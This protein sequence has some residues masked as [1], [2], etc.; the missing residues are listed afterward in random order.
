[1]KT[2]S[3]HSRYNPLAEAERYIASLTLNEKARFFILIEPGLGYMVA[4][5][6]K[7]VPGAKIVALHAGKQGSLDSQCFPLYTPEPP[8]SQWYPE[9]GRP[10]QDFLEG[11]IPDC[12]AEEIRILEWRP[13][14]AVYGGSYLALVEETAEFV[15][16]ADA[17]AKTT[18]SFGRR[19]VRNFFKNLEIIRKVLCPA[20]L[21]LPLLVTGAGPGL[22]E[23]IPLVREAAGQGSL[24]IL[25]VSSSVAALQAEG[26]TPN[27]VI[28]TDGGIWAAFHLFESCRAGTATG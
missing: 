19:W 6:R 14:L 23:A 20:P 10:V 21:S 5:L 7:R 15:K 26:I 28:C 17:N 3:L 13:A 4:P 9:T 24:F 12:Q 22:E 18:M 2:L 27:M 16:R 1:M 8:D 25:A 11:E